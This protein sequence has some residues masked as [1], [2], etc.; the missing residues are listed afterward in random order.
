MKVLV[1]AGK[2]S[3]YECQLWGGPYAT[4]ALSRLA[5]ATFQAFGPMLSDTEILAAHWER[6]LDAETSA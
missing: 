1:R 6:A 3:Y 4:A 5:T 2:N